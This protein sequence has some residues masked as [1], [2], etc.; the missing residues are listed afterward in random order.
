MPNITRNH[1]RSYTA[2]KSNKRRENKCCCSRFSGGESRQNRSCSKVQS[3]Q[4]RKF[5]S[6]VPLE[7][8]VHKITAPPFI[9][10]QKNLLLSWVKQPAVRNPTPSPPY[11]SQMILT[12]PEGK[13]QSCRKLE[14]PLALL[15]MAGK[16]QNPPLLL[17]ENKQLQ[18]AACLLS[19]V[20]TWNKHP[21]K[22]PLSVSISA[23]TCSA[24]ASREQNR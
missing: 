12:Q 23:R 22:P 24:L 7:Y 3:A 19:E 16:T 20:R 2:N 10:I 6:Q 8:I 4:V 17:K 18:L 21:T 1:T 5:L 11:T 14:S 15:T 9:T 13:P